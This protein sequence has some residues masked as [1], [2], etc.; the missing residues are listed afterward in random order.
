MLDAEIGWIVSHAVY[1]ALA[2]YV[3]HEIWDQITAP[4]K[5]KQAELEK[6]EAE[7][8]SYIHCFCQYFD[9]YG[10][11]NRDYK[12]SSCLNCIE[13]AE[14]GFRIKDA[15]FIDYCRKSFGQYP[16][17]KT[18]YFVLDDMR[19][20]IRYS[21]ERSIPLYRAYLSLCMKFDSGKITEAEFDK[22]LTELF[23]TFRRVNEAQYREWLRLAEEEKTK[24]RKITAADLMARKVNK[25]N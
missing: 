21:A 1:V 6:K 5:E 7:K 9:P 12:V 10:G 18:V 20:E 19:T 2:I 23:D 16:W 14:R 24:P 4:K 11:P 22:S 3:V 13:A 8:R 17:Y 25:Q 15:T